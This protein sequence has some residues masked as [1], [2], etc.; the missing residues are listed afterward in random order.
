MKQRAK[1]FD[2]FDRRQGI[3]VPNRLFDELMLDLKVA[4]LRLLLYLHRKTFELG[5]ETVQLSFDEL[6]RGQRAEDGSRI[7]KG[8]RLSKMALASAIKS[9]EERG[10]ITVER[11]CSPRNGYES[12][13]YRVNW[14]A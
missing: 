1:S 2:G 6:K 11:R 5:S 10:L 7:D 3:P 12:N 8:T 13:V 9:L 4:E 14:E